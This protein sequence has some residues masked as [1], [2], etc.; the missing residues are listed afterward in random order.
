MFQS[1][2]GLPVFMCI[3]SRISKVH[4]IHENIA[5]SITENGFDRDRP[6]PGICIWYKA[7]EKVQD[8][9]SWNLQFTDP[10]MWWQSEKPKTNA[11][12]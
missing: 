2:T 9:I 11:V 3:T 10:C 6:L 1:F 8:N 12:Y 5:R 4:V 7:A